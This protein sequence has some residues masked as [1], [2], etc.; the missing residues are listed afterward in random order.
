MSRTH[1]KISMVGEK[2]FLE[3]HGSKFGTLVSICQGFVIN[4]EQVLEL[5]INQ[6]FL[7]VSYLKSSSERWMCCGG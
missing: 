2:Y 3:D 1:C 7:K 5:Q 6:I 4:P